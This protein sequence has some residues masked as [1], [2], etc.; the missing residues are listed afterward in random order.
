MVFQKSAREKW[1][2]TTAIF[3]P[4]LSEGKAEQKESVKLLGFSEITIIFPQIL[5]L[6]MKL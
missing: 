6:A 2:K 4:L 1:R 3:L 5:I